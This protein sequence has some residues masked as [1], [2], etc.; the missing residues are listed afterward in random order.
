MDPSIPDRALLEILEVATA[1]SR[2][3]DLPQLLKLILSKARLLTCADAGSIF[4]VEKATRPR[5]GVSSTVSSVGSSCLLEG[6]ISADRLWFAASQNDS[7]DANHQHSSSQCSRAMGAT[8]AAVAHDLALKDRFPITPER[9]VGWCALTGEALNLADVYS[10][11][12]SLP[13]HFDPEIDRRLGYHAASML[14]VPMRIGDGDVVGVLQ[15]I[16]RRCGAGGPIT[17]DNAAQLTQPFGSFDQTLIEAL[18]S[19]AAESVQRTQLLASQ[20][21]L[22]ES[23]IALVAGAIDAK[24]PYTGGHCARVPELAMML[25]RA[26]EAQAEIGRA[27]V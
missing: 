2:A 19:L 26:A 4:L 25:A 13:Y 7:L 15:L 12:P 3:D 5:F 23:I 16:N 27:H 20:D 9:L 18:A 17:A 1:I 22:L 21:A 24:S 6:H 10:L 11:D 14:V 8:A